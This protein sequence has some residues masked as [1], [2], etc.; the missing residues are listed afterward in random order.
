MPKLN[1]II[2]VLSGKKTQSQKDLTEVYKKLQKTALFDGI[3]RTYQPT[4]EEGETQ[5]PEKKKVQYSAKQAIGDAKR[6]LN[7]LFNVTAT[8]DFANCEAR[9][10]VV[11]D[12]N[13]LLENVP[14][15][16]LLFLEKQLTD[17]HTFVSTIPTLD[18]GETWAWDETSD[19][20]ASEPFITNRTKKTPRS[21]ILYEATKEHPAQVEM[22]TEDVK[23]GEWKTVK[24][25][26]SLP[27]TERNQII[28][29]IRRMKEAIK[30]ARETANGKDVEQL[31]TADK[32][33]GY[34]FGAQS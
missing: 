6:A 3:S 32:I 27:V 1:Q 11:V 10:D 18:S 26:G 30:F 23:I 15:T 34:L 19:C 16:H 20:Y 28:D 9:A 14:V 7:E 17:L 13:T 21:H 8:Q 2:A 25:S 22:Y 33:F 5:P 4:D 12:G 29:R 24:F 31:K